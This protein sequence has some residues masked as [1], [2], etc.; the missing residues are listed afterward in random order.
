MIPN[1]RPVAFTVWL[2]CSV[3]VATLLA[4]VIPPYVP[5]FTVAPLS[6]T[7]N[8][9]F[10][11]LSAGVLLTIVLLTS[12]SPSFR[13]FVNAAVAPLAVIVPLVFSLLVSKLLSAASVTVYPMPSGSPSIV[14]VAPPATFTVAAPFV[15]DTPLNVPLIVL[16]L[17]S[18]VN[19][20]SWLSSAAI[21]LTTCLLI[22]SSP[23]CVSILVNSALFSFL[24]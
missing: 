24:S 2:S 15:N 14:F 9:K 17:S 16:S 6:V 19:V 22:S 5:S 21:G 12:S 8:V 3:N 4:N 20:N 13:V 11:S 23:V 18:I 1:G 7:V 10:V